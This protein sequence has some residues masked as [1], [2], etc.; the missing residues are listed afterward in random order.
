ME[1]ILLSFLPG[2]N[3]HFI[4]SIKQAMHFI[5]FLEHRGEA[6]R[7]NEA[8]KHRLLDNYVKKID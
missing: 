6:R 2:L 1:S 4:G 7:V 3:P 8:V 5:A